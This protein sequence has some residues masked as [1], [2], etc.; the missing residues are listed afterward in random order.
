VNVNPVA[1]CS[2]A[3]FSSTSSCS[4]WECTATVIRFSF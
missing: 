4:F 3:A 1:S 2:T